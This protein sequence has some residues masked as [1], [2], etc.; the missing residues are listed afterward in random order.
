MTDQ[1]GAPPIRNLLGYELLRDPKQPE[2][3]VIAFKTEAG[4]T[5]YATTREILEILAEAFRKQAAS[6]PK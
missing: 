1:S 2:L 4:V 3:S 6:M 5:M